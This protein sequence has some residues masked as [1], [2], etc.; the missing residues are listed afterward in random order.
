[1]IASVK[2]HIHCICYCQAKEIVRLGFGT[3]P[4]SISRSYLNKK[5]QENLKIKN[6]Q[7][8]SNLKNLYCS[9]EVEEHLFDNSET[10]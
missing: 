3:P 4:D 6:F 8:S 2:I 9:K 10:S 5:D 1:M 7:I